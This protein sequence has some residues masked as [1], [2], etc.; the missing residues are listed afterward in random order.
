MQFTPL[1]S[2]LD[3]PVRHK[4]HAGQNPW[5][6]FHN[7]IRDL[8]TIQTWLLLGAALQ[9][10]LFILPLRPTY[11]YGPCLLAIALKVIDAILV[12]LRLKAN[13]LMINCVPGKHAAVI[14]N[15][16]GSFSRPDDGFPGGEK[17]A[18]F[19]LNSR[20]NH[21]LG[22]LA[23]GYR[24]LAK[25]YARM[26]RDL[27]SRAEETGYL[28]AKMWH[29]VDE[30]T[31]A[32]ERMT[33]FYFRNLDCVHKFAHSD[34]HREGWD[35]WSRTGRQYPYLGF[36]HEAYEV[37]AGNWENIYDQCQPTGLGTASVP[38]KDERGGTKWVRTVV[39]ANRGGLRT[40]KGRM[41]IGG[42]EENVRAYGEGID[43]YDV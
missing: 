11:Q 36:S 40:H 6:I 29:N 3:S 24:K 23:P 18:V 10:L 15:T 2:D 7:N 35:W 28:G 32:V 27:G 16:D 13:P 25:F 41:G 34:S 42:G 39:D 20:S 43:P 1:F 14:P 33:V 17:I 37:P 21:P 8:L 5:T 26:V 12:A 4:S 22:I 31:A 9:C 19:L 38:V 30:R